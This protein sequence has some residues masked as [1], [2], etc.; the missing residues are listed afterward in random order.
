MKITLTDLRKIIKEEVAAAKKEKKLQQALD[1][2]EYYPKHPFPYHLPPEES[3]GLDE[4]D[5]DYE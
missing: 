5:S 2:I 3:F 4:I 1:E